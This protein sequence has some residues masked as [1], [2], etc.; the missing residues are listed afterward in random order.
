[1]GSEAKDSCLLSLAGPE[2]SL[3][4]SSGIL[5][6]GA[7]AEPPTLED[8]LVEVL[9]SNLGVPAITFSLKLA[10]SSSVLTSSIAASVS[11]ALD[12]ARWAPS[13]SWVWYWVRRSRS[14]LMRCSSMAC[15][16]SKMK[17]AE[18]S[19]CCCAT[20]SLVEAASSFCAVPLPPFFCSAS[21]FFC[22]SSRS[23]A[24]E[25]RFPAVAFMFCMSPLF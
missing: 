7:S 24:M 14:W 11:T 25:A 16:D 8:C 17:G 6:G 19:H 3:M 9:L 20:V 10:I 18:E 21:T 2:C 12:W 4:V 22:A 5:L 15:S 23:R 13:F 1:M